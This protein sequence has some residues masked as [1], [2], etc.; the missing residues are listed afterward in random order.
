MFINLGKFYID[1]DRVLA[2][3]SVEQSNMRRFKR[4]ASHDGKVID[5]TYGGKTKSMLIMDSGHA[6]LTSYEPE[7]L[8]KKIWKEKNGF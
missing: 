2:I 5:L 7:E 6:I 1:I 8:M 3:L 4:A